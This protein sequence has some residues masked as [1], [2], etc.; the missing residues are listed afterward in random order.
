MFIKGWREAHILNTTS[1]G[2]LSL[3]LSLSVSLKVFYGPHPLFLYLSIFS[4]APPL[5]LFTP[6]VPLALTSL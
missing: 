4:L 2:H 6:V 1:W 5:V 3:S